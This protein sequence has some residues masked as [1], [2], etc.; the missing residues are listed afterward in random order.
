MLI[1][2]ELTCSSLINTTS[3]DP[4][5][6]MTEGLVDWISQESSAF[7]DLSESM[8]MSP[9]CSSVES[10]SMFLMSVPL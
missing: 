8:E 7:T 6:E 2:S 5:Y 4:Q 1:E 10:A 3:C 9:V